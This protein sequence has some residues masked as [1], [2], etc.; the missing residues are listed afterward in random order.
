MKG[1]RE[2]TLEQ[3]TEPPIKDVYLPTGNDNYHYIGSE[4]IEQETLRLL[5]LC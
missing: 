4:H 5:M 2:V 3:L 1:W